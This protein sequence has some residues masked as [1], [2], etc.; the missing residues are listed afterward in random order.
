MQQFCFTFVKTL[1]RIFLSLT[2]LCNLPLVLA[3]SFELSNSDFWMC[4]EMKFGFYVC[5]EEGMGDLLELPAAL[6][7]L[8][9]YRNW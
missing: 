6:R 4:S 7:L 3:S 1:N 2:D 8:R 9:D 5:A